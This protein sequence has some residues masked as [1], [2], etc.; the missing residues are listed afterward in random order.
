MSGK[1]LVLEDSQVVQKLIKQVLT[2]QGFEVFP[3]K[4]GAEGLKLTK[5]IDFDIMLVDLLMP[6]MDGLEF[7]KQLRSS[8]GK[9][10]NSK[11]IVISGNESNLKLEDLKEYDV[12]EILEKPINFDQLSKILESFQNQ[13]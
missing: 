8:K 2:L 1:I 4:D 6:V 12:V 13:T 7:L 3:A 10:S 9:N 11:A 5:S